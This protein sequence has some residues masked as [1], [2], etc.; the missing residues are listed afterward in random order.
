MSVCGSRLQ[1]V[2]SLPKLQDKTPKKY[3]MLHLLRFLF[4][5]LFSYRV[6][7]VRESANDCTMRI[8]PSTVTKVTK[9]CAFSASWTAHTRSPASLFSYIHDRYGLNLCE[10]KIT[11]Y[12]GLCKLFIILNRRHLFWDGV[13][14]CQ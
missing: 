9:F 3:W 11:C 5:M 12:S 1:T 7:D 13:I 2:A 8:K 10:Q 14:V 6:D 4:F